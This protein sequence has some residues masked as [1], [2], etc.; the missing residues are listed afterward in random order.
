[1]KDFQRKVKKNT[2]PT[3]EKVRFKIKGR[4]KV[5]IKNKTQYNEF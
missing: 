3:K 4:K 5:R 2:L 1:M